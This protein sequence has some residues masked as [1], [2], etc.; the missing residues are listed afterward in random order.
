MKGLLEAPGSDEESVLEEI[1]SEESY[2]MGSGFSAS[3]DEGD[4]DSST[5]IPDEL[6]LEDV[7]IQKTDSVKFFKG[8]N[9][10]R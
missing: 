7:R 1:A 4:T 9:H 5:I 3:M 8:R 6:P 2:P 10:G